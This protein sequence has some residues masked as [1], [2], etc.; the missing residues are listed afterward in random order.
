MNFRLRVAS[1]T[2]SPHNIRLDAASI[3]QA[4][5]E[6]EKQGYV[7]LSVRPHGLSLTRHKFPLLLFCQELTVLLES[8]LLLTKALETL[9]QKEKNLEVK[10]AQLQLVDSI[11]SGSSFSD[12]LSAQ[13]VHF[14]N[15]FVAMVRACETTGN[16]SEGLSRFAH[17]LEQ[18]DVL[19][20]RLVSASIYPALILGFGTLV[21]LFLLGYVVPRFSQI[22]ASRDVDLS[23]ASQILLIMGNAVKA[24]GPLML[25]VFLVVTASAI[26]FFSRHSV[27]VRIGEAITH[28]PVI[29]ERIRI[30]HLSRFYRTFAMLLRSGIP[31]VSA[32]AMVSELLGVTLKTHVDKARQLILD[33]Q[34]FSQSMQQAELITPVAVQLFR[35]G[36][37]AGNLDK[38]MERAATFHEEEMMRWVDA[39]SKL[40]EPALMALLGV[41]IGVIVFLMYLP[42]FELASGLS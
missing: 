8:G 29:G 32:L 41:V 2:Y 21:M 34:T 9:S 14:P 23:T 12:A 16:L 17:Y 13:P 3:E 26:F 10:T 37:N 15:L 25:L 1:A 24:H 19:K 5:S 20:K 31:V 38:M 40:V 6:A 4:R 18:I 35:V 11:R 36:E 39:F 22:Y 33:G 42:I 27:R 7:V 30:Y 28:M